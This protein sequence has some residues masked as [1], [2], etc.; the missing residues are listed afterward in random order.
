MQTFTGRDSRDVVFHRVCVTLCVGLCVHIFGCFTVILRF[1]GG[2]FGPSM[3]QKEQNE[4]RERKNM[5]ILVKSPP[6]AMQKCAKSSLFT[7][8]K[9]LFCLKTCQN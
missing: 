8:L 1:S 7:A 2:V 3:K 4:A 9:H 6:K 5:Q